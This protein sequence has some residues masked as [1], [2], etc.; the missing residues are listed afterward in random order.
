MYM[1][2]YVFQIPYDSQHSAI[3]LQVYTTLQA[4]E[5][6]YGKKKLQL[7][8]KIS[9]CLAACL[10]C[11]LFANSTGSWAVSTELSGFVICR[12]TTHGT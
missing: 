9:H 12:N 6:Y 7:T 3:S 4:V 11:N 8:K 5:R 1:F 10:I 2:V